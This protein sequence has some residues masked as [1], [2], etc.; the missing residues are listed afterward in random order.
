MI[1]ISLKR[2]RAW[3][4]NVLPAIV[5]FILVLCFIWYLAKLM[6]N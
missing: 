5:L 6:F 3:L 1:V 4:R 2:I